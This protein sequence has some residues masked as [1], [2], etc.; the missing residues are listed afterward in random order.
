MPKRGRRT[1]AQWRDRH[2]QIMDFLKAE[3]A[4]SISTLAERF[5]CS[6]ATIRRDIAV[7]Q[8]QMAEL[9]KY[10]GVVAV[11]GLVRERHFQD[12]VTESYTEKE[13]IAEVACQLIPDGC[14]LGLNGGT[15][16]MAIAREIGRV[17]KPVT[18]VT[19]AIN[20]AF[21]L[22]HGSVTVVVIG[23]V[24]RASNFETTGLMAVE[25]LEG[26]HLDWVVLGANGVHPLFGVSTTS[27]P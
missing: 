14:V 4:A 10:H 24:L 26:L 6:P 18:V 13:H 2:Q 23:G 20:V 12:K 15:T 8:P 11:E 9:K 19:N 27:E 25:N 21:E 5:D 16:T 17:S 22:S 3:G 7:I 1:L